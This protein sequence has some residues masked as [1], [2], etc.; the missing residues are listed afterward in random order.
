MQNA[1][2]NVAQ[3]HTAAV[4]TPATMLTGVT[5]VGCRQLTDKRTG[6]IARYELDCTLPNGQAQAFS[7][8]V[9]SYDAIQE[10]PALKSNMEFHSKAVVDKRG[11]PD[12]IYWAF[13][14]GY[15][16]FT[17]QAVAF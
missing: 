14:R 8:S 13:T 16:K 4:A 1:Q 2:P 11:K 7:L 10:N 15:S 5:I 9:E 3:P 6:A 12:V 17:S